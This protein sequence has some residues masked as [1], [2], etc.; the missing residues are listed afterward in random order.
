LFIEGNILPERWFHKL[1]AEVHN[2]MPV[3]L[4]AK[5][6]EQ[7]ER[8]DPRDAA[9]LMKPAAEDVLQVSLVSKRVNSSRAD[10]DDETLI[11]AVEAAV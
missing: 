1:V 7:W 3:I 6:F 9:A 11:E 8:G 2:R 10:G 4:E 5:D